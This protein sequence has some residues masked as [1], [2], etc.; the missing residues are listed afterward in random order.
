MIEGESFEIPLLDAAELFS[1]LQMHGGVR[2]S[3]LIEELH[4][5]TESYRKARADWGIES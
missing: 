3:A 1:Q 2:S 4:T 5:V